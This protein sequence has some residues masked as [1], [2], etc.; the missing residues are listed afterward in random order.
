MIA[1]TTLAAGLVGGIILGLSFGGGILAGGVISYFNFIWIAAIVR[2][3]IEE[4][5]DPRAFGLRLAGK[6]LFMFGVVGALVALKLVDPIGL[7]IGVSSLLPGVVAAAARWRPSE[8]ETAPE[9]EMD[10]SGPEKQ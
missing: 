5:S 2:G 4:T 3:L 9:D 8:G 6:E 7:V 10:P 1:G